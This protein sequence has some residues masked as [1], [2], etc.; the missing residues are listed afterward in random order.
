[1]DPVTMIATALVAGAV[2]AGKDVATQTVKDSYAGLKAVLVRKFGEKSD[3]VDAVERMNKKPDS[4]ARQ[5]VLKE[6]LETAK[7]GQDA[8]VVGQ[9]QALLNLL[10]EHGL[11]TGPSY[12]AELH[13][14]GAIAQGEGAAAAGAGGI[15]VGGRV[16]GGIH[17]SGGR[18]D[19]AEEKKE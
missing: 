4:E 19:D 10:K 13:G 2:A 3:V 12:H 6:E 7:A 16:E 18:A 17:V 5:A 11:A 1:M 9:A 8:E 14:S 15:A